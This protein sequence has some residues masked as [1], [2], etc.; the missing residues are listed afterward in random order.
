MLHRILLA[1]AAVFWVTM[2]V[3]L[4]RAEYGGKTGSGTSLPP[5]VV[6]NK[7]LTAPD[8]SS[9]TVFHH[10]KKIGFCH[11]ATSIGEELS[12]LREEDGAPEGMVQKATSY[13]IQVEGSFSFPDIPEHARFDGH[14]VLSTN[15]AWQE[16]QLRFMLRPTTWEIETA[17]A[18]QE[19]VL[20][21]QE[22]ET[23]RRRTITFAELQTPGALLEQ[24]AGPVAGSLLGGLTLAPFLRHGSASVPLHWQ[25]RHDSVR[26][27][28]SAVRAYRLQT[29]LLDR[30]SAVLYISRV[31]EI[32]RAELPG[33]IVLVN[34]ALG[35]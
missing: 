4:W 20:T 12:A 22:G 23:K 1:A 3:L 6:W 15:N 29:T 33:E 32:L 28:H 25:A 31:G 19:M 2:T 16:F 17:A 11:W 34:D 24:F 21:T 14:L 8:S 26:M 35:S 13:R 9:L 5:A 30:Y 7:I 10:G 27:G 18:R